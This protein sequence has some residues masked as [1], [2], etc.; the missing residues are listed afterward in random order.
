MGAEKQIKKEIRQAILFLR[1]TSQT[2]P[3]ETIEFMKVAAL[4]KL[5]GIRNTDPI[6][7]HS[8]YIDDCEFYDEAQGRHKC[9][10]DLVK[11]NRCHGVCK[12]WKHKK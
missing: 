2:I 9:C 1:E 6:L 3:S 10:N 5:E 4:E 12:N 11:S 7:T 8:Q